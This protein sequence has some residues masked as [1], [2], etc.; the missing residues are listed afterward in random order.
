MRLIRAKTFAERY[1]DAEDAPDER[2]VRAWVEAQ[3]VAGKVVGRLTYVDADAFEAGG[4]TGN[5][6]ADKILSRGPSKAAH[7]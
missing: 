7:A 2:T 6:L 4:F 1:F 5:E 3:I